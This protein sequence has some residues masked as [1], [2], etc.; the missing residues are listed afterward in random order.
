MIANVGV[1]ELGRRI[2]TG[3]LSAQDVLDDFITRIDARNPALNAL[4]AH[5]F[6]RVRT[7]AR[8][9]DEAVSRGDEVGA[10]A[11][12]PFTTK[13]MVSVQ[14]LPVTAGSL[15]RGGA[16]AKRDATCVERLR[17]AGAIVLGVSN[18]SE[19]GLWLESRNPVYGR[20]NNPHDVTRTC[21]GSSGGEGALVADGLSGFGVGSDLGGSIRVPSL[22]CG[23]FGHKPTSNFVPVTG[24]FPLDFS[25]YR[26][27]ATP[28][29]RFISI[30]PMTRHAEDLLGLL[31]IMGGRCDGD[32]DAIDPPHGA[33]QSMRGKRVYLLEDPRIQL[34]SHPV[35]AQREAVQR[36]GDALRAQGADVRPW[37][38]PSLKL[39]FH[40]FAAGLAAMGADGVGLETLLG[41]SRRVPLLRELSRVARGTSHH[42]G[43]S[44]MVIFGDRYVRPSARTQQRL[45][46]AGERLADE[47]DQVLGEDGLLVLPTFPRLAPH[48][49]G[50]LIHPFDIAYTGVFNITEHPVTA[51]PT[52]LCGGLPT[53]VQIVGKRNNDALPISAAV[54]MD[55]AGLSWLPPR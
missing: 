51:A 17:D 13:E 29:T 25:A 7:E 23:N 28:S 33:L 42:T 16:I 52:G 40:I 47:L 14:G 55:R 20:T 5:D 19:L 46:D 3:A 49:G 11:G 39:A 32:C 38:G 27:A 6:D 44:L 9:V 1:F 34:A 12:V 48:H 31:D 35:P 24:H 2:R 8:A 41:G 36:A 30:G 53:G 21:G 45:R 18:Q 54:A 43:A 15:T 26:P 4:V 37:D 50:T 10:L 22:F